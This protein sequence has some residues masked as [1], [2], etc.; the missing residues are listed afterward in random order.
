MH[1]SVSTDPL[2]PHRLR[3]AVNDSGLEHVNV[4][5]SAAE[6][7]QSPHRA[8]GTTGWRSSAKSVWKF[9]WTQVRDNG[10]APART[11]AGITFSFQRARRGGAEELAQLRYRDRGTWKKP[12][13][14]PSIPPCVLPPSHHPLPCVATRPSMLLVLTCCEIITTCCLWNS[15]L[16]NSCQV[17]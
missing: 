5:L 15:G 12:A 16:L 8:K 10:G 6:N 17:N 11:G 3:N 7:R 13:S 14:P 2:S 9:E 1:L 4:H